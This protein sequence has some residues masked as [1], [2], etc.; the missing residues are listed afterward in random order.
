MQGLHRCGR[1][2]SMPW[3]SLS[4]VPAVVRPLAESAGLQLHVETKAS[5]EVVE[6]TTDPD[7]LREIINNLL[8][9]AVQYNKPHGQI[10]LSV[11][12]HQER[13]QVEV[14]DTGIGIDPESLEHIF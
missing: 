4:N 13:V 14:E 1:N 12:R 8:H 5:A 10:R 2:A 6:I 3:N 11:A 9:N 7:K